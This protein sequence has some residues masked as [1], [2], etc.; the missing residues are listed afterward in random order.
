MKA[1]RQ[2]LATMALLM[3]IAPSAATA[4][5]PRLGREAYDSRCG[6]CHSLDAN[7]VGPSHRGVF[8]RRAGALAD[9]TYSDA[10]RESD[11]VWDDTN[12]ERWLA[13]PEALIPGQ[14]MNYRIGDAAIRGD[15]IAFL[16]Q[17]SSRDQ[18][19]D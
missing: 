17:E 2:I 3:A 4:G 13:D 16:K 8:G 9:Y 7:R 11:V 14:R 5:D 15:I 19:S 6:A 18:G 12:L 1:S 10:L